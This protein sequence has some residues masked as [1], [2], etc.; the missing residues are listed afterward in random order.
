[1]AEPFP[2]I[3]GWLVWM[4]IVFVILLGIMCIATFIAGIYMGKWWLL[5]LG[6]VSCAIWYFKVFSRTFLDMG[7]RLK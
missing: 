2:N 5:I 1:M 4:I 7:K 3:P 6:M